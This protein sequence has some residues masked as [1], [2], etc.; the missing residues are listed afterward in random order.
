MLTEE[1]INQVE[2]EYEYVYLEKIVGKEN[3]TVEIQR[4]QQ[5]WAAFGKLFCMYTQK[6][7]K[8]R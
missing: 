1:G 8:L 5:S 4:L 2:N 6:Q 7:K 3:Q